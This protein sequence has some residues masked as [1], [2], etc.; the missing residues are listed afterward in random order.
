MLGAFSSVGCARLCKSGYV[1]SDVSLQL[2]LGNYL[3]GLE[4]LCFCIK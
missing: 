1:H 2:K 3:M 4:E